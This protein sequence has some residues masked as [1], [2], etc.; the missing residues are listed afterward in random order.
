MRFSSEEEDTSP[1]VLKAKPEKTMK[2]IQQR[3]PRLNQFNKTQGKEIRFE[4]KAEL[5][6]IKI[7]APNPLHPPSKEGHCVA[8]YM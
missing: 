6:N 8:Q 1:E 7:V 4:P 5:S 3:S 2:Q